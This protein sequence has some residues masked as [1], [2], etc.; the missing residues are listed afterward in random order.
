MG[1]RLLSRERV[2]IATTL[3]TDAEDVVVKAAVAEGDGLL[4]RLRAGRPD[5]RLLDGAFGHTGAGGFTAYADPE[6]DLAF[7]V[8]KTHMLA[9]IDR[10]D[11]PA[12]RFE[13]ELH[14]LFEA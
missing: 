2:A 11:D 3:Q 12:R 9:E 5:V 10:V 4:S 7:A 6:H 8:C 13:R 14:A 1:R